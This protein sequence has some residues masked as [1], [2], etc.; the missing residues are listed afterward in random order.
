MCHS[1]LVEVRGP[2]MNQFFHDVEPLGPSLGQWAWWRVPI[3]AEPSFGINVFMPSLE[4]VAMAALR[5]H[6]IPLTALISF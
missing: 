3:A 4:L 1:M 5:V 6:T 2:L